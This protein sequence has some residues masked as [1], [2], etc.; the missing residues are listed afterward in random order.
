MINMNIQHP[1]KSKITVAIHRTFLQYVSPL[2]RVFAWSHLHAHFHFYWMEQNRIYF[3]SVSI[4]DFV[5]LFQY[6]RFLF[7]WFRIPN[8]YQI[9]PE[10]VNSQFYLY[11]YIYMYYPN[12]YTGI[13]NLSVQIA[14]K[15][16]KFHSEMFKGKHQLLKPEIRISGAYITLYV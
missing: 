10:Y 6:F 8:A 9:I 14:N 16:T 1:W 11:I 4:Q 15:F 12:I 2:I 7:Q 3:W 5:T 13:S